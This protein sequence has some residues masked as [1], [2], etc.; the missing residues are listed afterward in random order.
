M[1]EKLLLTTVV[2]EPDAAAT[3]VAGLLSA[4]GLSG[5][6]LSGAVE[7]DFAPGDALMELISFLGCSPTARWDAYRVRVCARPQLTLLQRSASDQ[8]RCP[9]CAVVL[10]HGWDTIPVRSAGLDIRWQ[11]PSCS[12][13]A[14]LKALFRRHRGAFAN[15]WVEI[16]GIQPELAV[17]GDLLMARLKDL[18]GS[19]WQYV[20]VE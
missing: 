4:L 3:A 1:T 19:Q 15:L 8:P 9:R 17:P 12:A 5:E 2:A 7:A 16:W 11:C 6:R 14:V 18:T 13:E 10:E 20:Y